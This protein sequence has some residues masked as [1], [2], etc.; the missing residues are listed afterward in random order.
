ML[1]QLDALTGK[2]TELSA[3][4][5]MLRSENVELRA[6]LA[7]SVAELASVRQR[8]T[9]ATQRLDALIADLPPADALIEPAPRAHAAPDGR[10]R[11]GVSGPVER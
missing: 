8:T 3:R 11:V 2:L 6:Q 10:R 5:K 1:E 7:A 9:A 4:V